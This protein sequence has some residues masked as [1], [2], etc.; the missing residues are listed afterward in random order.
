MKHELK[1]LANSAVEIKIALTAEE[2]K[3]IK[4]EV[5]KEL[6]TKV[7]V[8]GFRKGHVPVS[9]V[10]T[11]FKDNIKEEVAERVLHKYYEEVIKAENIV[12]VSY[13]SNLNVKLEDGF[14]ATFNVDVYPE[15][16]LG[17]YKGLEVE[18]ETF[19]MTPEVLDKE[20]EIMLN[21][22]SKLEDT[23]E[24][25]KAQMGDTIDLAFEGFM[26][27]VPFEGGKADSHMLK[28]GSH[29]FI[30]N[31]EDQLV[32]YTAGQEGE[33][34]VNFP[35]EYHAANLAG[36]PAVFKVKVNAIKK[37]IVPELTDEVAKEFGAD[38]VED[39]KTKTTERVT[40]REE[41][42]IKNQNVAKLLDK[43]A[44]TTEVE[45]PVSMIASEV[46]ARIADM[47]QQF[48][49]Q[50]IKLDMYLQMTGMDL[51]QLQSQI[52]PMAAQKVKSDLM[53][54]A[55][56]KAENIDVTDEEVTEKMTELAKMYGMDLAQL[57]E[58]L[59]K[60][61]NFENFK[62]SVKEECLMQKAIEVLVKNAK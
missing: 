8:P 36:K 5:T 9:T 31:F 34:T 17:E 28:L 4:D 29:M 35:E 3:P 13:I 60:S 14:E 15:V 26:D 38:S 23:E 43:L 55:I 7:E 59:E 47:E 52:A 44:E 32:G 11:Q 58:N 48:G 53:L 19:E 50:G 40:K 46:R 10:E 51:N 49:A 57:K 21:S 33:I 54:A 62:L 56:I 39:L 1:K 20:I 12:P 42:R 45:V 37:L 61:K 24:G 30:D 18:K 6:A 16:K 41:E 27:G 2:V 22:K 25:Y